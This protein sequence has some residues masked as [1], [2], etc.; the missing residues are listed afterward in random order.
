MVKKITLIIFVLSFIG[1]T[2]KELIRNDIALKYKNYLM[3]DTV[4]FDFSKLANEVKCDSFDIELSKKNDCSLIDG[5]EYN[6]F[7]QKY[8]LFKYEFDKYMNG[9]EVQGVYKTPI[10]KKYKI[11]FC[12]RLKIHDDVEGF[13]FLFQS[14]LPIGNVY[15]NNIVSFTIK[16][17]KI[18]S[19][20]EFSEYCTRNNENNNYIKTFKT[21]KECYTQIN[22]YNLI[23]DRYG[24]S[25]NLR[26]KSSVNSMWKN[27]KTS[28]GVNC[29]H[30][31]L[32]YSMFYIDKIGFLRF[33]YEYNQPS[34][35][36]QDSTWSEIHSILDNM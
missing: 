29:K 15:F 27:C 19:I 16:N 18:C 4:P 12:G 24:S 14:A 25:M 17:K 8:E 11:F 3:P 22:Y 10:T 32:S 30:K 20:I 35:L 23:I 31:K 13:L 5:E 21:G 34:I 26:D 36:N 33:T 6:Y 9:D 1:C 7:Y 2:H 28:L